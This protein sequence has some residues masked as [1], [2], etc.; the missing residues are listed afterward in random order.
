MINWINRNFHHDAVICIVNGGDNALGSVIP[1]H[2]NIWAVYVPGDF[3]IHDSQ[4][5]FFMVKVR[6][7]QN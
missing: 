4:L 2:T 7:N 3:G 1:C 5:E 6:I